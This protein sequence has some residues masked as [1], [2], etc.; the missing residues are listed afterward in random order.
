V[1][2][3]ITFQYRGFPSL[4]KLIYESA[5]PTTCM[6]A[7]RYGRPNRF[8]RLATK[9][10]KL[11]VKERAGILIPHH[12][13][14][15]SGSRQPDRVGASRRNG[16]KEIWSSVPACIGP[17]RHTVLIDAPQRGE[18]LIEGPYTGSR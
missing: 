9:G 14:S 16:A 3:C 5:V 13:T 17:R 7:N 1:P 2:Y 8:G 15:M 18:V 4:L 10:L 11:L 6:I 12:E